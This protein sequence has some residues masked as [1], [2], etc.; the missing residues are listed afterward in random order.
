MP[1]P[2][3]EA[4]EQVD[5]PDDFFADLADEH[6]IDKVIEKGVVDESDDDL[7]SYVN[8]INRL[9]N[10]IKIR[11]QKIKE[12][13]AN[14]KARDGRRSSRSRSRS[15]SRSRRRHRIKGEGSKRRRSR[16]SDRKDRRRSRSSERS[17]PSTSK[18]GRFDEYIREKRYPLSP[19]RGR[20]VRRSRS[21]SPMRPHTKRSSSTH[22]NLSFLDEL[23]QTFAKKGQAFPERDALLMG[24]HGHMNN[25]IGMDQPMPMDFG[26]VAPFDQQSMIPMNFP[27]QQPMGFGQSQNMFYGINPMSIMAGNAILPQPTPFPAP[28]QLPEVTPNPLLQQQADDMSAITSNN[29]KALIDRCEQ[30]IKLIRAKDNKVPVMKFQ[31]NRTSMVMSN[32]VAG[33]TVSSSPLQTH[34]ALNV[35]FKMN[36]KSTNL[37]LTNNGLK[38]LPKRVKD[39]AQSLG[40]NSSFLFEKMRTKELNAQ[41]TEQIYRN[42]ELD[43]EPPKT[44]EILIQTNTIPHPIIET[45][46]I[47]IQTTKYECT[48]CTERKK[49]TMVNANSQTFFRGIS[50]G[51]QTNEKDYREPIV[52]ILSRMT[53]AQLVAIKDFANIFDE[54]RPRNTD[55]M[56]KMRERLM[57]IY[58]LSQ[59][60]AD[61]VNAVEDNR[62]DDSPSFMEQSYRG[63][64]DKYDGEG[65]SRDFSRRSN[66]PRFNGSNM[67]GRSFENDRSAIDDRQRFMM[68]DDRFRGIDGRGTDSPYHQR[69]RSQ[70]NDE[71]MQRKRYL[72]M[73]RQ[74]EL[75]LEISQ[76]RYEEQR[77]M[78]QERLIT[79]QPSFQ[80]RNM[81]ADDD[82]MFRDQDD[83]DVQQRPN[84]FNSNS[85][86]FG[87]RAGVGTMNKRGRGAFRDNFRGRGGGRR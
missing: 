45:A 11:K 83:R 29:Q 62:I 53:A 1:N 8:E 78:E 43:A 47:G 60:D 12:T 40:I 28:I 51:V 7:M 20:Q 50:I 21:K 6:F 76:R 69:M 72:E 63:R 25:A 68:T 81:P 31:Y 23:A 38:M 58:S 87:N 44:G 27:Q 52:E 55:E 32:D 84:I 16:S 86:N 71:D 36:A 73:E 75:E 48:Q 41:I 14:L 33:K 19:I 39:V 2:N 65:S 26:N 56:Y 74:R 24:G 64:A 46:E 15:N 79:M 57:D 77:R 17:P 30:A 5:L 49:R 9:Q 85:G 80:Q 82:L 66:S 67:S 54:P 34:S 10:D 4:E 35:T 42:A 3:Q 70:D 13:E 61:I 22:R 37:P 59:R 18:Q